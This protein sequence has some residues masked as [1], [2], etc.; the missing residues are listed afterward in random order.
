MSDTVRTVCL[1]AD[2]WE[3]ISTLLKATLADLS[4]D[5]K[6]S[7]P[8]ISGRRVTK[9]SIDRIHEIQELIDTEPEPSSAV[10]PENFHPVNPSGALA[11]AI[12]RRTEAEAAEA[13]LAA[14]VLDPLDRA[15]ANSPP[16]C[17]DVNQEPPH[18]DE[19]THTSY[20][21]T[22]EEAGPPGKLHHVGFQPEPAGVVA[23][24][25]G[26]PDPVRPAPSGIWDAQGNFH[27]DVVLT[28]EDQEDA[29]IAEE[30]LASLA[31]GE[32][33]LVEG[34]ELEDRLADIEDRWSDDK[35]ALLKDLYENTC[36]TV[37]EIAERLGEG[38]TKGAVSGKAFRM[39]FRRLASNGLNAV[40]DY[41]TARGDEIAERP[42][43]TYSINGRPPRQPHTL[44]TR[45]N[46]Y[47]KID[48]LPP[49][50]VEG[51]TDTGE[52]VQ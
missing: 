5:I 16:A 29:R 13:A 48:G 24:V 33:R 37:T 3:L 17:P 1:R 46:N 52:A 31:S 34:T 26:T 2:Q 30:R 47:R 14:C 28:P 42:D 9:W 11:E 8:S 4:D 15:I 6:F 22:V 35:V 10:I 45:A 23:V 12:R 21:T 7:R 38:Y 27:Q 39:G 49:L 50:E 41:L 40:I 43:G 36:L 19:V 44:L 25:D 32:D 20:P 18:P 51:M